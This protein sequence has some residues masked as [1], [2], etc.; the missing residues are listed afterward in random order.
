MWLVNNCEALTNNYCKS[1]ISCLQE[2]H[3]KEKWQRKRDRPT[4]RDDITTWEVESHAL[5]RL[6]PLFL[7]WGSLLPHSPSLLPISLHPTVLAFIHPSIIN[8]SSSYPSI[9]HSSIHSP[10]ANPTKAPQLDHW[11]R[12]E[13]PPVAATCSP[14]V[15]IPLSCYIKRHFHCC[16]AASDAVVQQ[17]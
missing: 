1:A 7:V 8:H 9:H 10:P 2:R 16:N 13:V 11:A 6:A 3:G 4:E 5:P 15:E 12:E 17:H 14:L